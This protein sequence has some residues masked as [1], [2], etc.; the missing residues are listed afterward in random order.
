MTPRLDHVAISVS[1]LDAAV[2]FY[3]DGLGLGSP[4]RCDLPELRMRIAFFQ[5]PGS[6]IIELVEMQG[7]GA[8]AHGEVI[9]ALEVEDLDAAIALY[10]D[11]GMSVI[12]LPP[13]RALPLRRGLIPKDAAHGTMIELC[14]RDEVVR[15][16]SSVSSGTHSE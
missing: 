10:R 11:R 9:V 12:D 6:R 14:Q 3:G 2:A 7:R 4:V 15:F 8:P 5:A 16:V 1:D 13:T